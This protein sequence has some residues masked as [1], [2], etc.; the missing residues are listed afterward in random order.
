MTKDIKKK[1]IH[2]LVQEFPEK[3][4]R[5]LEKYRDADRQ[6]EAQR[7]FTHQENEELKEELKEEQQGVCI[8]AALRKDRTYPD[9][10]EVMAIENDKLK[11]KG[12]EL[13]VELSEIKVVL[14]GTK[15]VVEEY[16]R[17]NVTLTRHLNEAKRTIKNLE[18]RLAE[19]LEIDEAHQ[20][21]MGKVQERLTEVEEDNKK[22]SGQINNYLKKHEDNIRKSGL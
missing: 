19:V 17:G 21:Q 16:H 12:I 13:A 1:S 6:E 11:K 8:P 14:K 4:Y 3:T 22:L 18:T 5:E 15:G 7:I 2:E 20:K 10:T 9:L